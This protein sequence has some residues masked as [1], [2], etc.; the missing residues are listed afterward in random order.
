[1][2]RFSRR[3]CE[4]EHSRL[5]VHQKFPHH[6]IRN[7]LSSNHKRH[8]SRTPHQSLSAKGNNLGLIHTLREVLDD[9][10]NEH[11]KGDPRSNNSQQH[12]QQHP[13]NDPLG[14]EMTR[15]LNMRTEF[16]RCPYIGLV[17]R[18]LEMFES[19]PTL[20]PLICLRNWR[21][22][23][24][25]LQSGA[26][27]LLS[28]KD[29]LRDLPSA[30]RNM[31][32]FLF[33]NTKSVYGSLW[34]LTWLSFLFCSGVA[35]SM[36]F[37]TISTLR[38]LCLLSITVLALLIDLKELSQLVPSPFHA[39]LDGL[40]TGAIRFDRT[41]LLGRRFRGREWGKSDFDY[42]DG[43]Q[44]PSFRMY[45]WDLP[46]PWGNSE[47]TY[48]RP[49][50]NVEWSDDTV[51]HLGSIVFCATM[52]RDAFTR[53][54]YTKI[55]KSGFKRKKTDSL[56]TE[57]D[58]KK[59]E[60]SEHYD[61]ATS[62]SGLQ[63]TRL[64]ETE[65]NI[66]NCMDVKE[67]LEGRANS[68]N[69]SVLDDILTDDDD[70]ASGCDDVGS[71]DSDRFQGSV[72]DLNWIDVGAEIGKK[73]L[74]SAA[75]QKAMTSHDT[76]ERIV[77]M[78]ENFEEKMGAR[79][80]DQA[81]KENNLKRD[82]GSRDNLAVPVLPPVHSMWTSAS[83]AAQATSEL[84]PTVT[85]FTCDSIEPLSPHII[86]IDDLDLQDM[87]PNQKSF[88]LN[89]RWMLQTDPSNSSA[90]LT[91]LHLSPI[92]PREL[93][94]SA[95]TGTSFEVIIKSS[96]EARPPIRRATLMAGVKIAVPMFPYQP[97]SKSSRIF[98]HGNFQMATV[99]SSKRLSIFQKNFF[100]PPG[101]RRTNCLSI[102]VH[103]DKSFL[104]QGKFAE[105]SIRIMDDWADR[106]MPKHSKFPIGSC[107]ATSFGVGVLVGWRVEDDCHVVR[108]LWQRRGSG[109]ACAYLQREAIHSTMGAANGFEVDT[110][111]GKGEVVGYTHAGRDF[112]LGRYLVE[113]KEP[114][115]HQN[116]TMGL[117]K[118]DI[119][120]CKSA[121]F[122]PVIEHVREA[123]QYQ[124]QVDRYNDVIEE[125]EP[126]AFEPIKGKHWRKI[127]KCSDILWKSFL[128]AT[129]EDAGFD[130]GMNDFI[131][132]IVSF[133]ETLDAQPGGIDA[134]DNDVSNIVIT[135][136]DSSKSIAK[137]DVAESSLW[138]MND[139][140]G[141][142]GGKGGEKRHG[143]DESIEIEVGD[144]GDLNAD[145]ASSQKNYDRIFGVIRTL[146][147][148]LSIARAGC[149]DEPE[150]K[151]ALSIMYEFLI[152]VKTVV[153]V[154]QKNMSPRSLLIWKRALD[155]IVSTFGPV[156]ERIERIGKGIADRMEKQGRRAKVRVLR[157]VDIIVQD[158]NL[159]L[160]ME[161]GDWARCGEH[162]EEALVKSKV[163]DEENREHYHRTA[164]YI[165]RHFA[166]ISAKNSN[167]V[168][169]NHE[170]LERIG[171]VI[172]CFAA[173]RKF[174]LHFLVQDWVLD[175]LER[176]LVRVFDDEEVAFQMLSI[177][178]S[179]F[180]SLRQFRMLK[181]FA[182]A[183]KFWMPLLDAA[184]AEFSF[185]VSKMPDGAKEYMLPLSS[186]FSLCV[187]Q[188]HKISEGD[189]T[190]DWLDFLLEEEAV[191]II[192]DI[193]V[194]LILALESFSRDVKEMMVVLPY[195]PR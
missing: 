130:E 37:A 23:C 83:A 96:T 78:R 8:N 65:R 155:E 56:E 20:Q 164:Q 106:Y 176:V 11:V 146:M 173:P 70:N 31:S 2:V 154:Q 64:K 59:E 133:F 157:F 125:D 67:L 126:D 194:K 192:H 5:G 116:Q 19:Y 73:L 160:S 180:H 26:T 121:R 44:A 87:K 110:K 1:M 68:F 131:S 138:L 177:H 32:T 181:D 7:M 145:T 51:R 100:P 92:V 107:V 45:L 143:A 71:K 195:Y 186:L 190:K 102:K 40:V 175:T 60:F 162:I 30:I 27:F 75:V 48:Q 153:R 94:D 98:H 168:A 165:Y 91:D 36:T 88:I 167:A 86:T 137:E 101:K 104:R 85:N 49:N 89:P 9:P 10:G 50:Q 156:K 134:N 39:I 29:V 33:W 14:D 188:F 18:D 149:S 150:F 16:K 81:A 24:G 136:T 79:R 127:S 161:Q 174:L 115:K 124:L 118:S 80:M 147:R 112:S 6:E 171:A 25:Q 76:A 182:V 117:I 103:L 17:E 139:F 58:E 183:G 57:R 35:V 152:F 179:N 166:E 62:N 34:T 142:F 159:L 55:G 72:T 148:T 93:C 95:A 129:E 135:A 41:F 63:S 144:V 82:A 169:R 158:D 163:I 52:L 184:D 140:F 185:L 172:R 108:S 120:S 141:L 113:M 46:P 38:F 123:V 69:L 21:W 77:T 47:S 109:S 3:Y 105:M 187:L 170:K 111:L 15:I 54:K 22:I 114:G 90:G 13:K 128:R 191:N 119:V 53:E 42:V 132:S 122:I 151:L 12:K 193:D 74:G 97:G 4:E 28:R 189:L 84:S 178:T 99:V 61:C 43:K 66:E